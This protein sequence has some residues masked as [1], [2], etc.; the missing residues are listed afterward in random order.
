M[1]IA[2]MF[3]LVLNANA[4]TA[5]QEKTISINDIR[6]SGVSHH[7]TSTASHNLSEVKVDKSLSVNPKY[8][9]AEKD[10]SDAY[11]IHFFKMFEGKLKNYQITFVSDDNFNKA[12][13]SWVN[14][15]IVSVTLINSTTNK[16]K[17]LK[18]SQ[19]FGNGSS[20]AI[21]Q[22]SLADDK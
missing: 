8:L 11:H 22:E 4:Q 19:T 12:T 3:S 2:T 15:T 17:N 7:D 6:K 1:T 16:S 20:A 13:Y 18:L 5:G 14:D 21:L 10:T 9:N